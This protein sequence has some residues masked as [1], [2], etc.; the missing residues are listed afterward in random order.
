MK[1]IT[2]GS[3]FNY[4]CNNGYIVNGT[5]KQIAELSCALGNLTMNGI[6]FNKEMQC[7]GKYFTNLQ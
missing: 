5:A 7:T 2:D 3:S 1:M 6:L 4:T